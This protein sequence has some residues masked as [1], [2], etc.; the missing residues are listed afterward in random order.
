MDW[1]Y[2]CLQPAP[3]RCNAA[4]IELY[5]RQQLKL[6]VTAVNA[7]LRREDPE[8]SERNSD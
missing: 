7:A 1:G 2:P 6:S 8:P 5:K 4:L 3:Q